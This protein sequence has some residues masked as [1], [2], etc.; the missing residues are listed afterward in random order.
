MKEI[1][2]TVGALSSHNTWRRGCINLIASENVMSPLASKV[3]Q[4]DLEHR[5]AEG[6]PGKRYYQGL[7]YVDEIETF[8]IHDDVARAN[9]LLSG[10]ADLIEA[11]P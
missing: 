8:P 11:V 2:K 7:D 1:D 3:Y 10:E 5:Y 6:M 4:S 9:A